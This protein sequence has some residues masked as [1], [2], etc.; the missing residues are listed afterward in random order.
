MAALFKRPLAVFFLAEVPA[1][2][3]VM[4]DLRRLPGVGLRNFSPSLH[5]EMRASNERRQL[6]LELAS[7]L[8]EQIR[9]FD[10][11][12][13]IDDNPEVVG[14]KIRA[15]LGVTEQLQLKWKDPDG[16][17]AFNAWRNRIEEASV[18]VFQTTTFPSEE[19]S[20]FCDRF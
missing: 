6:S 15:A 14:S 12:A 20:G 5:M 10:L 9:P 13:S 1:R 17:A 18:L 8:D 7:D 2:F 3:E 16:R 11:T 19:A 4:R